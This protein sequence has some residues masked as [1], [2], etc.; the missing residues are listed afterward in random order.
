MIPANGSPVT[1]RELA[2]RH[3][4]ALVAVCT[5]YDVPISEVTTPEALAGWAT[6]IFIE[7]NKQGVKL[8]DVRL[9]APLV[10]KR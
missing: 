3:H 6:S 10:F 1:F 5:E 7:A 9:G 4:A 2:R 8:A